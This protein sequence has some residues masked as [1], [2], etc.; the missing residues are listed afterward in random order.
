MS[1]PR[2]VAAVYLLEVLGR[3]PLVQDHVAYQ[4]HAGPA[5]LTPANMRRHAVEL[6][7][8]QSYIPEDAPRRCCLRV[9]TFGLIFDFRFCVDAFLFLAVFAFFLFCFPFQTP[10]EGW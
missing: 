4:T 6:V 5:G 9:H 2:D 1:R 10:R 3:P 8:R 7:P